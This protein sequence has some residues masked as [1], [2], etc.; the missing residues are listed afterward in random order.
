MKVYAHYLRSIGWFLSICTITMNAVFQS[1]SIGANYWMS[2]WSDDA[3]MVNENGT[4]DSG[5][6][7][8]YVSVYALLGL[9]Q[10][11]YHNA[12]LLNMLLVFIF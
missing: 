3:K 4:V 11:M 6:R 7:N 5:I 8:K 10:G 2:E 1:F 9:G 12:S